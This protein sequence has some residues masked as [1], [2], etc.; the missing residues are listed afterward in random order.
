MQPI[1]E[2][3]PLILAPEN[4]AAWLAPEPTDPA[5]LKALLQPYP[6]ESMR[7]HPVRTF[8]STARATTGRI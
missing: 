6:S 7:M 8:S 5:T 1:H 2:R 3:M 4:Y